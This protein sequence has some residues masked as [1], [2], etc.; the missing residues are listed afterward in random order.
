[1]F[2]L[3]GQVFCQNVYMNGNI[4]D[5]SECQFISG[6]SSANIFCRGLYRH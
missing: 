3:A 5:V 6:M 2:V 1:M 4:I